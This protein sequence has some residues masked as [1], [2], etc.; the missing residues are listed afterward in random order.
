MVFD[1]NSATLKPE[2]DLM[3]VSFE[4]VLDTT[5]ERLEER[6]IQYSLRRIGEMEEELKKL[7]KELDELITWKNHE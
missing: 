6:Q 5:C 2:Y 1:K 7:E 4:T 3:D